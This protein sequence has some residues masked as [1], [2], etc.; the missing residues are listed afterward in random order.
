MDLLFSKYASPFLFVDS[1]ISNGR[2]SDLIDT[3]W[4]AENEKRNWEFF[5]HKV[6]EVSYAEFLNSI[7]GNHAEPVEPLETTVKNSAEILNGFIPES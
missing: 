6:H 1:M 7:D 2:F 5:L 3:I 4:E